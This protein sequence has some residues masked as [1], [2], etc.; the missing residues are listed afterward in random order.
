MKRGCL[1]ALAVVFAWCVGLGVA[2]A[3]EIV[4][5]T[6]K[7]LFVEQ[8]VE[9]IASVY[10]IG[11]YYLYAL[12]AGD[13]LV[14]G[15]YVGLKSFEQASKT[16]L[17]F[18]PRLEELMLYGDPNVEEII[19]RGAQLVLADASRHAEFAKQMSD[20]GISAIEYLVET[21]EALLAAM[22]L[23]GRALGSE[24]SARAEAFAADFERILEG[25]SEGLAD[26]ADEDRARVLFLGTTPLQV[27]SGDMYQTRMIE[28]AGG[29]SVSTDL[30]GY[31]NDV[32]F[33]QILLWDPD[34]VLIAPYGPIQSDHLLDAA[35]WGAIRAIRDGRVYRMPRL[36]APMDTPVP[37]SLL[38]VL[39]MASV[40]YPDRLTLDLKEEA[41][42]FYDDY[43]GLDLTE[44]DVVLLT[45]Q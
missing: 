32:N 27:A 2:G 25:V 43:Y 41:V 28:A 35:D 14:A 31:W 30:F 8:P 19:G 21:P 6:G 5:Q 22:R 34:V 23:T 45:T 10:G 26:L 9:R 13:R 7:I 4:D 20:L 40:L 15:W 11:T 17:R 38:G 16:M 36:I 12:G 1:V 18:E 42:R 29:L 39:W 3:E 44:D 24:A 33:E 37:E